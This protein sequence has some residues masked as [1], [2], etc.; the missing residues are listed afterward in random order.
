MTLVDR[1]T[2]SI[3]SWY[4]AFERSGPAFQQLLDTA[5]RARF[6]RSDLL[7]TYRALVYTPGLRTLMP[8]KNE[9]FRIEGD[10]SVLRHYLAR[11]HRHSR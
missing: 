11:L 2:S 4:V 9:T 7:A 10:N 5:P 8:D 3:L 6:H 1:T